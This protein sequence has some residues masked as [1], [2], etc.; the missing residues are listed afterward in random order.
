MLRA[1]LLAGLL[2]WAVPLQ[3]GEDLFRERLETFAR[4]SPDGK[5]LAVIV[6]DGPTQRLDRI[7]LETL[8]R[9]PVLTT[10]ANGAGETVIAG[11][12]WV[13]NDTVAVAMIEL[14][15]GIARL[16]DTR[17]RRQLLIVELSTDEPMVRYIRSSGALID[18]LP[19]VK[20][21][22]LFA[23][24]GRTSIV[25]RIR[26]DKLH[27][28]GKPLSK[29][30][31]V[32]GGQFGRNNRIATVE[33]LVPWWIT[34]KAGTVRAALKYHPD[35]GAELLV[36]ETDQSEWRTEHSWPIKK[37]NGR[38]QQPE[39]DVIYR[40]AALIEGSNDF[41]V[42]TNDENGRNGVYRYNYSS[43]EK[44]LI[45]QHPSAEIVDLGLGVDNSRVAWVSYFE[46]GIMKYHYI[47]GENREVAKQL[48]ERFPEYSTYVA[49]T[50]DSQRRFLLYARSP[51]Q[52]GRAFVYEP[53]SG[54]VD[55][56]FSVMPWLDE[57]ALV[58]SSA[59]TVNSHGLDIEYFLTLPRQ[60][61]KVPLIVYPHGGPWG[62]LDHREFN[63]VVQYLASRGLAVLQVNYRGSGGYGDEF[64]EEA[65]GEFGRRMID[66]I[67]AALNAVLLNPAIDGSRIC[68]SGSSYGGYAALMLAARSPERFRCVAS[69]AG[70]TDLGLL[71]GSY[72]S[73]Q[74]DA[75]LS[76]MTGADPQSASGYEQLKS[77]SPLYNAERLKANVWLA[78]GGQ[79]RRVDIEHSYRL[80]AELRRLGKTVSW[81]KFEDYGHGFERP[82][83]EFDYYKTL[84]DFLVS[85]LYSSD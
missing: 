59:A 41:V 65:R 66:D 36:R 39:G 51:R 67:E 13:D 10:D 54:R 82:E 8:Q 73:E 24:P 22:V 77:M 81:H 6:D 83:D 64:L 35:T 18:A 27:E 85:N 16:S 46:D 4:M 1:S 60:D 62:I 55:E 19:A 80:L 74:S 43:G 32:D 37:R 33:G 68:T 2:L 50:D 14:T 3:A 42:F 72:A 49:A 56:L 45:Y 31:R 30:A 34:D 29:T 11:L 75:L 78:H 25:Y 71:L 15:D 70:V 7:D 61:G 63:P 38:D 23:R 21:E 26:T 17:H 52:P 69:F 5:L 20:D 58:K 79:D 84:A 9:S 53:G 57:E 44:S 76:H 40:P 47:D 48:A 12:E 28:W